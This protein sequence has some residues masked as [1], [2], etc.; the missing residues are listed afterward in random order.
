MKKNPKERRGH[1]LTALAKFENMSIEDR[2][3]EVPTICFL[4]IFHIANQN[5][6]EAILEK[7]LLLPGVKKDILDVLEVG[8]A[9]NYIQAVDLAIDEYLAQSKK[10]RAGGLFSDHGLM[11]QRRD[12]HKLLGINANTHNGYKNKNDYCD[13]KNAHEDSEG[14]LIFLLSFISL[15][16]HLR[17]GPG[18]YKEDS[19]KMILMRKL[20]ETFDLKV[21]YTAPDEGSRLKLSP[22]KVE[23]LKV[24]RFINAYEE[25]IS[26]LCSVN[27]GINSFDIM[28]KIEQ[29]ETQKHSLNKGRNQQSPS[30]SIKNRVK[31]EKNSSKLNNTPMGIGRR[32]SQL[33]GGFFAHSLRPVQKESVSK[34]EVQLPS[35]YRQPK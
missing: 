23:Q 11:G 31:I 25:K 29:I 32:L 35:N 9:K 21:Q 7:L 8:V 10:Q 33:I 22:L 17:D 24:S 27:K 3:R 5:N 30:S 16:K 13:L 28:D 34:K 1:V 4:E 15:R 12:Y 20:T 19:F 6:D 2:R 18:N 26:V 14:V